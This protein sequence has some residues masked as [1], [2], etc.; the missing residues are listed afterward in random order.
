MVKIGIVIRDT[1]TEK[2]LTKDEYE[3]RLQEQKEK[4]AK[5]KEEN[6]DVH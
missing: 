3:R 1:K 6:K 5:A 4:E 2:V